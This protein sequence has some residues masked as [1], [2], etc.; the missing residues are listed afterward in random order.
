MVKNESKNLPRSIDSLKTQVDE[1]IVV[2]TGSTDDTIT[3]AKNYGAKV[4]ETEWQ[5]DFSTPRNLAIDN[6]SGDWII[7]LDADEFFAHTDKIRSAINKLSNN[8]T[9]IIPRIDIDEEQGRELNH[10]WSLRIFR[11]VDYLRYRGLIHENLANIKGGDFPY[12]F[13]GNELTI[14]HT[15]YAASVIKKKLQR[16][17]ELIETEEKLYGHKPQHD[18]T[19]ADCY[20]GLGDYEKVIHHVKKALSSDIQE[21]TGRNRIYRNLINAMRNLKYADEEILTVI[22]EAI[23]VLPNLPEFYAERALNLCNINK[24]DEAYKNFKKSLNVWQ[25]MTT[26]T[27]ENS[28]FP[29]LI[30]I[31]YAQLAELE[32]LNGNYK[33]AQRNIKEAVKLAPHNELY[34][35]RAADFKLMTDKK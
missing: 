29:R 9:I 11:N 16:N 30:H 35:K 1:I 25:N 15:G 14:Y 23:K 19:L 3:I 10:D 13:S 12:T 8:T 32:A 17:L 5:G 6:A 2:D 28:Y 22:D 4:I 34:I 18:I 26:A 24:L 7:F 21:L 31:V 33:E 20:M 27:Y